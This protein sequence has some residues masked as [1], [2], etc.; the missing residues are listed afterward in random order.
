MSLNGQ[1]IE[2][3]ICFFS[4]STS[5][6]F[7]FVFR[8]RIR[9]TVKW[10]YSM[11][12]LLWHQTD[13]HMILKVVGSCI[14]VWVSCYSSVVGDL[15]PA[16]PCRQHPR[17]IKISWPSPWERSPS[18]LWLALG[19][20]W[21][22]GW[23]RRVLTRWDSA[24]RAKLLKPIHTCL[25]SFVCLHLLPPSGVRRP[26]A[27]SGAKERRRAFPGLAEGR[28]RSKLQT[29]R[30]LLRLS[31]GVVWRLPIKRFSYCFPLT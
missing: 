26:R 7:T 8:G 19:R 11:S 10:L 21:A 2:I 3:T 31:E 1:G 29:A 20:P 16:Q 25:T 5:C 12:H 28:V 22:K 24:A 6:R 23:R 14:V 9:F 13:C 27:V 15:W 18:W 4:T 17:N 30:R